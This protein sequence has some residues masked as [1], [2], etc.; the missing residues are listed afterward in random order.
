MDLHGSMIVD[1]DQS[2]YQYIDILKNQ[3]R[4]SKPMLLLVESRVCTTQWLLAYS[5]GW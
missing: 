1:I 2:S 5:N 3:D 4:F